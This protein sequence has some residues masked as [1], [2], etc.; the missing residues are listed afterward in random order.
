MTTQ[1]N[2]KPYECVI[3]CIVA[4]FRETRFMYAVIQAMFRC[5][6]YH[7][8]LVSELISDRKIGSVCS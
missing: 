1:R 7:V 4:S 6:R 5:M 2:V 8:R 3:E